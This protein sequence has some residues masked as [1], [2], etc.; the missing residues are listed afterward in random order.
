MTLGEVES[1]YRMNADMHTH[2]VY[3]HGF[4]YRHGKGTILENVRAAVSS[5]LSEIAITDHGPG[6]VFYGLDQ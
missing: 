3:S 5:G 4:I 1:K 6:H 2:S